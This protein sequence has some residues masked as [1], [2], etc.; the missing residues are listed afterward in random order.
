MKAADTSNYTLETFTHHFH[1]GYGSPEIDQADQRIAS[2]TPNA[3]GLSVR[4][5]VDKLVPGHIHEFHFP[6]L[7]DKNGQRLL[8][9]VAYYT[10]NRIPKN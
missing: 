5:M 10:L 8:H 2:A 4:L 6:G 9:D 1:E 3:D 7:R